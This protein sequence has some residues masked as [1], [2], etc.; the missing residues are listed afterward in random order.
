MFEFA[1]DMAQYADIKVVGIGG[2]GN[3]AINRM[4][5]SGLTGVEFIAVNT[6]AQA[7]ISSKAGISLQIGEKLTRGLGAGSEPKIGS[8]AAEESRDIIADA[9]KGAD[10][11]FL[12]A[13]LGGGTGTGAAPIIAEIS[14]EMGCLTVGIITKPFT[15]EGKKRM[16]KA[17]Q[18][19]VELK[20]KVDT[21]ITIPND[22]LLEVAEKK[23]T[24]LAAF[25]IADDVLRQGVQGISDLITITGIINLDFA[26]VK[27]I[28]TDAGSALMGIG[29]AKGENR[30]VEAAKIASD[31]P[32]LEAKIDGARGVLINITGGLDLGLHEANEAARIISD[33]ADPEANIILGAVINE[34]LT[35]EVMVTVIATGFDQDRRSTDYSPKD[36]GLHHFGDDD[37][38]IPAFLRQRKR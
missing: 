17:N 27:T 3:N 8:D 22:R 35:E 4:I 12:T 31:S 28:M 33:L 14:K 21:L 23:T 15:V 20:Q 9:L 29:I 2:G 5:D 10:M 16:D 36:S 18:G 37:L 1:E 7:L 11:V 26:D 19:I 32:L 6:D 30:A 13:G 34:D 25:S 38:D 24:L